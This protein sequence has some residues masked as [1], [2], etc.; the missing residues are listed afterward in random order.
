VLTGPQPLIALDEALCL[1]GGRVHRLPG[2]P[3]TG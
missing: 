3:V 2:D 1:L